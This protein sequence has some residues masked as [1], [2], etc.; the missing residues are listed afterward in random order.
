MVGVGII[1]K[2]YRDGVLEDDDE[3]AIAHGP[4][5]IGFQ[6]ASEAMVN[7][8]MTL[9]KAERLNVISTELRVALEKIGKDL[10]YP[11][12]NYS[13][14]FVAHRKRATETIWP[15]CSG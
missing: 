11:D 15:G 7:I 3:V 13:L 2:Q 12:R 6:A 9:Q 10:F 1:F 14:C 8:R 4:A 5:E